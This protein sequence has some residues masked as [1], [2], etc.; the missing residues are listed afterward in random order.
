MALPS[1]WPRLSQGSQPRTKSRWMASSTM[2]IVPGTQWE[3]RQRFIG[4]G[5]FGPDV[6]KASLHLN[7]TSDWKDRNLRPGFSI[8]SYPQPGGGT[9]WSLPEVTCSSSGRKNSL[10]HGVAPGGD[11]ETDCPHRPVVA[12]RRHLV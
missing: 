10:T 5:W 7:F 11:P 1:A 9:I 4:R 12:A 8:A 3:S 2:P 6:S